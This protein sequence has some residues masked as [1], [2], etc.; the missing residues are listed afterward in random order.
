MLPLVTGSVLVLMG[1]PLGT[2]APNTDLKFSLMLWWIA[3]SRQS[4]SNGFLRPTLW[5]LPLYGS[6]I[7]TSL[8]VSPPKSKK[9]YVILQLI[10]QHAQFDAIKLRYPIW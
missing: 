5:L 8:W 1:L 10:I 2:T 7:W 4:W 6:G 3:S 9:T